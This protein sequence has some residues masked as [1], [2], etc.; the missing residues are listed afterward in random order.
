VAAGG[1]MKRFDADT[2]S[3]WFD[4]QL[5][6][7]DQVDVM[8]NINKLFP[9]ATISRG[10]SASPLPRSSRSLGTVS[11]ETGGNA[12]DLFDYL[13]LNRVVGL[14]I[15]KNGEIVQE[16]YQLGLT[17]DTRWASGSMAKSITS[18]LAGVALAEGKI[19]SLDDQIICYL[20]QLTGSAYDGVTVRQILQMRSGAAWDET[21]ADSKSDRRRL[22]EIHFSQRPER[23]LDFMSK[24]PRQSEPGTRFHYSTGETYLVGAVVAAATGQSLSSY[25][26]EKIWRPLGMEADAA[27]WLLHPG[28]ETAG[29]GFA[30]TLRD[31]GRFGQFVMNDGRLGE[32]SLVRSGWFAE[33][34]DPAADPNYGFL[35]WLCAASSEAV[36]RKAFEAIGV[37]GQRMYINP[38]EKL[39]V[40]VLS[41]RP[42]TVD[43]DVI[44]DDL[45][46]AAVARSLR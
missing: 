4:G 6:P 41:A 15:L 16:T 38:P 20:P 8:S 26:S 3:A 12:Y 33:A 1:G 25:L 17:P 32:V 42:K 13:A 2:I 18:T 40:V 39:V 9:S 44:D 11:I 28:L 24:L 30:A 21:Y 31:Y 37:Y 7:D 46:F 34:T 27:W 19:R 45:F 35:W 5:L 10:E 36:H 14:L 23:F 43:R 29:G 22:L